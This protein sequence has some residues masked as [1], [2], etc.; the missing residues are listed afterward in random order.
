MSKIIIEDNLKGK[1]TVTNTQ[2]GALFT[3]ILPKEILSD[4]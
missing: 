4:T 3:I 2:E 1:I